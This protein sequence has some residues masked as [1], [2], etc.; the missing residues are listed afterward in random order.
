LVLTPTEGMKLHLAGYTGTNFYT[1]PASGPL[2]TNTDVKKFRQ[3]VMYTYIPPS[4]PRVKLQAEYVEGHDNGFRRRSWYQYILYRP[5]SWWPNFE[6]E[7]RYEQFTIDTNRP[8]NTLDRHTIGFN[9]YFHTN[10]KL[11]V[12]YEI[13]H[14]ENGGGNTNPNNKNFFATEIQFRY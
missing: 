6:P 8:H 4:F 9:Y 2:Q 3:G 10:V 5:F 7:Y 14:D 1:G 12:N 11:T 13:K